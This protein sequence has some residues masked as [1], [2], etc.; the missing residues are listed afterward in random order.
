MEAQLWRVWQSKD[1]AKLLGVMELLNRTGFDR[2]QIR[3]HPIRSSDAIG[4][5]GQSILLPLY[6]SCPAILL[7]MSCGL[8]GYGIL[9]HNAK[10]IIWLRFVVPNRHKEVIYNRTQDEHLLGTYQTLIETT[11]R[12]TCNWQLSNR[13]TE[14]RASGCADVAETCCT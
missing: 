4:C 10:T 5:K 2:V 1:W 6:A 14:W 11:L 3:G 8:M 13:R 9:L 12:R 7:E